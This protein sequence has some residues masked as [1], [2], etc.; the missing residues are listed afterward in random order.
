MKRKI[1]V[2]VFLPSIYIFFAV[3]GVVSAQEQPGFVTEPVWISPKP[4]DGKSSTIFTT[5]YNSYNQ[6]LVG[7]VEFFDDTTLLGSKPFSVDPKDV[8]L[9]SLVWVPTPGDHSI[10]VRM[11]KTGL[12][13]KQQ[14]TKVTVAHATS[15]VDPFFVSK[16]SIASTN[17]NTKITST[18]TATK[19]SIGKVEGDQPQV[20]SVV[21]Q[22]QEKIKEVL[23]PA[24]TLS[25]QSLWDGITEYREPLYKK[26]EAKRVLLRDAL[27][28]VQKIDT[29]AVTSSENK[30]NTPFTFVSLFFVTLGAIIFSRTSVFVICCILGTIVVCRLVW[31]VYKKIKGHDTQY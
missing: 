14:T 18:T 23:D 5:V 17:S 31:V 7:V 29:K 21:D 12:Q 2:T 9:V 22:A 24:T 30:H 27:S 15:E 8:A 1:Y 25:I 19:P 26:I 20:L 4:E 11:T 16:S 28:P 6:V 13:S 10:S 3:F